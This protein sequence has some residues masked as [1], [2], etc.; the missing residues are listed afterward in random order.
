MCW[1][2]KLLIVKEC[3]LI[4]DLLIKYFDCLLIVK[5]FQLFLKN[6]RFWR[7]W[8]DLVDK[9]RIV[10][11]PAAQM[12]INKNNFLDCKNKL[13]ICWVSY[14]SCTLKQFLL[15]SEMHPLHMYA[16]PQKKRRHLRQHNHLTQ[17]LTNV[18]ASHRWQKESVITCSNKRGNL[19]LIVN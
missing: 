1:K 2:R 10:S 8:D 3:T 17:E 7:I 15:W 5:V 12:T 14:N 6:C 9:T 11:Q 19:V 18:T 13:F 16:Q 4:I